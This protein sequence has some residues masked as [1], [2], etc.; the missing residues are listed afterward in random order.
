MGREEASASKEHHSNDE[1]RLD[2]WDLWS[3]EDS[4]KKEVPTA[5]VLLGSDNDATPSSRLREY[6]ARPERVGRRPTVLE[7]STSV[8][9][10][11]GGQA[12]ELSLAEGPED[13]V[14]SSTNS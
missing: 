10:G 12:D 6:L 13:T 14:T 8:N 2:L 4:T 11:H 3:A 5:E 7:S 1:G 9:V